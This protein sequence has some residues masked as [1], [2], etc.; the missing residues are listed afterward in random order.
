LEQARLIVTVAK[1]GKEAIKEIEDA[2]FDLV[3]MDLQ[4]PEMGGF[5]ATREIRSKPRFRDLPIV[6]MTA[7]AIT[8]DRDKCIEAGMN[9]Y[10]TKPIDITDLFSV[11]AKWIKPLGKGV[12]GV[13]T[14]E[15]SMQVGKEGEGDEILP[16]LPGIDVES[17]LL[18]VAGNRKLY[19]KLLIKFR[20][21]YTASFDVLKKT[22]NDNDLKEAE[23]YAHTI[24]GVA[25][26]IG[27]NTLQKIASELEGVI[28]KRETNRYDSLLNTYSQ[29][30]N[31]VLNS[32]QD[33][34]VLEDENIGTGVNDTLSDDSP[35]VHVQLLENLV[36]QIK[37]RK[38]KKCAPVIEEILKLSWTETLE[39][40]IKEL[41][42]L[43]GKYKFKEAGLIA[44]TVLLK[45][46]I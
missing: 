37:T 28:R 9:D 39:K 40:E 23:I 10:V 11:L 5:E 1:N 8:G 26:N 15:Q 19:K 41:S 44:E 38:P 14:V 32:L 16:P 3:L 35:D 33:L 27:V 43:I 36:A 6:A 21:E 22:L 4:M 24:K 12:L 42:H 20:D 2:Q 18:R 25:G 45:L 13:D 17:A 46:K 30:L 31:L 34:K 29:E 7:Q